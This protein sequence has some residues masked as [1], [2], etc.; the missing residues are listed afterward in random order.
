MREIDYDYIADNISNIS[1]IIVRVYE[2]KEL[3]SFFNTSSFPVDPATP[4]IE[5]L[6]QIKK[7]VGYYIT[8]FY[9]Y[10]GVV[11]YQTHTLI[12]G[13]SFQL[14]PPYAQI[15][16][17]MFLL[18]IKENYKHYYRELINSITP[19]PLELFLHFLCMINYYISDEKLSVADI[20]L[21]DCSSQI[22]VQEL[23]AQL[24]AQGN[25]S[26]DYPSSFVHDTYGFEEQ[27]LGCIS[28]GD[29]D[30]LDK[31][32][33]STSPG[34]AGKMAGNY[35]RQLK[36]IFI[37]TATLVARAAIKGGMPPDEALSLSDRYIQ[38]SEKYME[39]EQIINLQHHMV[40]DY[41]TQVHELTK[42]TSYNQFMRTIA[43]Y[44]HD[45][46]SED[47]SVDQMAKDLFMSRSHLSTKFKQESGM[48]LSAYIQHQKI[49]KAKEYLKNSGR[50]ILEISTF[51]GFSSQGYFQ[52]VFKKLV[53]MT[54]KEYREQ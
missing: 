3:K 13:P 8:P 36:N 10:Y 28:S 22:H 6:L 14:S 21:Y 15:R 54:P 34:Q 48:T 39:V 30:G 19:M 35:L 25:E 49:K 50:S 51:L 27:M 41:A 53:G 40:L 45:H 9:Q 20:L 37:A 29:L 32:F 16:D 24:E 17:Y 7:N 47:I 46:L 1:R 23:D 44:V 26:A 38:H 33:A 4:Y 43:T 42:G 5:E 11:N 52:N 31:L 2:N 12:I 18:G